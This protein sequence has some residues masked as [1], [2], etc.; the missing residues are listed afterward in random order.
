MFQQQS[1]FQPMK[2][3]GDYIMSEQLAVD[4]SKK[5]NKAE[6]ADLSHDSYQKI[7]HISA[8]CNIITIKIYTSREL[9]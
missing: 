9:W 8:I 4:T 1:K 6:W 2:T 7:V 3:L 5:Q